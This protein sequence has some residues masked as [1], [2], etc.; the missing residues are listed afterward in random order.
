[1]YNADNNI[2]EVITVNHYVY[3][4]TNLI[5]GKK[6]IGKRSCDCSIEEDKYIGSGKYIKNSIKKYGKENF[7]KEI[8]Q[9]CESEEMAYEWEKVYIEQVK[10]YDN[11]NYYNIARGGDG[12]G[13]LQMKELWENE[14][15][16]N[17]AVKGMKGKKHSEETK[18]K[19]SEAH[20]GKSI[21]E[22]TK[23]KMS[24]AQKGKE[25]SEETKIKIRTSKIGHKHSESTKLKLRNAQTGKKHSQ[26]TKNKMSESR[27][28]E[29]SYWY[30]KERSKEM[31]YKL[32]KK[33]V[34]LNTGQVF[35][36]LAEAADF[37]GIK[38]KS[39]I[40]GCCKGKR[41]TSGKINGERAKWAYLEDYTGEII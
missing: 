5:N 36:S 15:F 23:N 4:T 22:E 11:H 1:M 16:R 37:I 33:V 30:N 14:E 25:L 26:E 6:Y 13:S 10:A 7:K 41:K 34:L 32:S 24:Q 8:L 9:I 31:K 38:S 40:V 20:K 29:K 35:N 28:G 12:L 27:K 17:K 18:K 21:S 2:K 39:D 3:E 19:M